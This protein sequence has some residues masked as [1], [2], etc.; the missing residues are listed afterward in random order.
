MKVIFSDI[1]G[2]FSQMGYTPKENIEALKAWEAA[3]HRFV[4]VSGRGARDIERLLI[5]CNI[6]CDYIF[7]NGAGFRLIGEEPVLEHYI[8]EEEYSQ[9]EQILK[10]TD[11]F[12]YMHT[13]VG[14]IMQPLAK[15]M[16]HFDLLQEVYRREFGEQIA[17]NLDNRKKHFQ[18]E[19]IF[20]DDPFAYLREHNDIKLIK[21]ELLDGREDIRDKIQQLAIDHGY[22]AFS[23]VLI[24]LEIVPPNS[25][26]GKGIQR[27]LE[28]FT[29]V[30]KT[31]GFGDAMNDLAMFETVDVSIAVENAKTEI[32][33]I[34]DIV[35]NEEMGT[36]IMSEML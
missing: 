23:S 34:C 28:N 3:G 29:D 12:Y 22:F 20:T 1:D 11:A 8:P 36:Y 15:L 16:H 25:S 19:A 2:T 24:N 17:N 7:G 10:D 4:F 14:V 32:K 30:E 35:L 5:E 6:D 26:K 13:S 27:Y 9:W 31:Y 21:F 33:E 18:A